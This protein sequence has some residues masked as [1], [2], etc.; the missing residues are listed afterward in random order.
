MYCS[1]VG[2]GR[3][4]SHLGPSIPR[5]VLRLIGAK[6]V[7]ESTLK[8]HFQG[9]ENQ[10]RIVRFRPILGSRSGPAEAVREACLSGSKLNV[11]R[12]WCD[13]GDRPLHPLDAARAMLAGQFIAV[14]QSEIVGNWP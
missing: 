11:F 9:H 5:R 14:V 12:G 1:S 13:G 7:G 8:R 10:F 6:E 2:V 4:L 3:D